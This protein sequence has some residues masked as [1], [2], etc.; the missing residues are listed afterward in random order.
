MCR[1]AVRG[2]KDTFQEL[3]MHAGT[4]GRADQRIVNTIVVDRGD[5][6]V[7]LFDVS[8][9]FAKAMAFEEFC[10]LIGTQIRAVQFDIPRPDVETSRQI[11]DFKDHGPDVAMFGMIQ[12]IYGIKDAPGGW[13]EKEGA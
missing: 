3:E 5:F 1:F 9:A 7:W 11:A 6:S 12:L 2:F 4:T 13:V 10:V 8:N